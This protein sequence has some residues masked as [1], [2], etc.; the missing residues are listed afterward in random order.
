MSPLDAIRSSGCIA[1]ILVSVFPYD[2]LAKINGMSN[3]TSLA[4]KAD[5]CE[6]QTFVLWLS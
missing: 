2:P 3:P 6:K 4:L 5:F 1:D